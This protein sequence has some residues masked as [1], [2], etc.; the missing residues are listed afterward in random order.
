MHDLPTLRVSGIA[1]VAADE[2][3]I[4]FAGEGAYAPFVE[5]EGIGPQLRA[6]G[7]K[8]SRPLARAIRT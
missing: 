1:F 2:V 6:H 8:V 5:I 3:T 7:T 4:E